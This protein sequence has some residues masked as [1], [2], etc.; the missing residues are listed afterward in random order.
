[1]A[2]EVL[3]WYDDMKTSVPSWYREVEMMI[4]L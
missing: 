2:K 4:Q 1:M 3:F